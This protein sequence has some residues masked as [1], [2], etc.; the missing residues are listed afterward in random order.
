MVEC[1]G[2]MAHVPVASWAVPVPL[3]WSFRE[4]LPLQSAGPPGTFKR[5]NGLQSAYISRHLVLLGSAQLRE[6]V[7]RVGTRDGVVDLQVQTTGIG[8]QESISPKSE[9]TDFGMTHVAGSGRPVADLGAG[10]Q[11]AESFALVRRGR[12]T[13][14]PSRGSAVSPPATCRRPPTTPAVT[15]SQS[16]CSA[17]SAGSRKS[18]TQQ[19]AAW[20]EVRESAA[21]KVF[22]AR[23]S[24]HLPTTIAGTLSSSI[25]VP[26]PLEHIRR[27]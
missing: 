23:Q 25:K 5:L 15:S 20:D 21:A 22:D 1:T 17:R 2:S 12:S 16:T 10:P 14:A 13:I 18:C 6:P 7:C 4:S 27:R 19:I 3:Q 11:F 9:F 26:T 24:R 8:Y